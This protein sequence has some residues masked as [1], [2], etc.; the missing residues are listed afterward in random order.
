[1]K[2]NEKNF[3]GARTEKIKKVFNKLRDKFSKS[4]VKVIRKDLHR[5]E[6]KILPHKK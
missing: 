2:E 5:I 3:D 1:M 4:K 6:K